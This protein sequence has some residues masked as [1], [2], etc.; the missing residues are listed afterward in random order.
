MRPFLFASIRKS[1]LLVVLLAVLPALAIVLYTGRELRDNVVAAA[2]RFSLQ[3][4]QAM[5]AHHER[6]VD[7]ARLLLETLARAAEVRSLDPAASQ[8]LLVDLLG[9]NEA[10]VSL[11][12]VDTA[13]HVVA[14]APATGS[15]DLHDRPFFR[16]AVTD[17]RF[18]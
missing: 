9:R 13:G 1:L 10:Y 2:E 3:Q 8:A 17:N 15:A 7:N 16:S 12:L 4:V 6:V 18:T 5:A 14:A 11:A